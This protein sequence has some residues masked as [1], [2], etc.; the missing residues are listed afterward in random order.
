MLSEDFHLLNLF[1]IKQLSNWC[2][3]NGENQVKPE[4][5]IFTMKR[6]KYFR[7]IKLV[8]AEQQKNCNYFICF[9]QE[10][11][12]LK[13]SISFALFLILSAL[14]ALRLLNPREFCP[15]SVDRISQKHAIAMKLD[16]NKNWSMVFQ[17]TYPLFPPGLLSC[18]C[19]HFL[20]ENQES[21]GNIQHYFKIV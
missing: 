17:K 7:K 8:W 6:A 1:Q 18:W 4:S 2:K 10:F 15:T 9:F 5:R 19:H 21:S 13:E 11:D 3:E 14:G 16:I 12:H 20:S